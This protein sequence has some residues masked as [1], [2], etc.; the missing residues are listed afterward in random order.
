MKRLY[1]KE[2]LEICQDGAYM[3]I[4][5]I[6]QVANVIKQ[7]ETSVH[8]MIGNPNV[9]KDLHHTVYCINNMHNNQSPLWTPMQV[10]GGQPCHFVPLLKVVC[11]IHV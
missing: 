9:R 1:Q 6:F 7:P 11:K 2:V 3:G 8:P 5:Q 10:N 4:W